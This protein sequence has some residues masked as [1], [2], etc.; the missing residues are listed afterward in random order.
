MRIQNGSAVQNGLEVAAHVASPTWETHIS[1][2]LMAFLLFLSVLSSVT[3]IF[4]TSMDPNWSGLIQ[5]LGVY[6]S[7]M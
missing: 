6:L 7:L 3:T 2:S 5:A 1:S 4:S